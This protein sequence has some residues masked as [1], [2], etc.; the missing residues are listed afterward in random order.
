MHSKFAV[1]DSRR[2]LVGSYNLDPRSERLNSETAIVFEQEELAG[3]LRQLFLE[4]DLRYSRE[5]S[6]QQAREFENPQDVVYR[7]RGIIGKYFEEDL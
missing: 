4:N 1:V 3:R 2:S 6:L 7:F 5:V